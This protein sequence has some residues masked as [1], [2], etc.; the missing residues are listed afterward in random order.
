V[1]PALTLL[2]PIAHFATLARS[3]MVRAAAVDVVYVPLLVLMTIATVLVGVSAWRFR[4]QMS[5]SPCH[6]L[7]RGGLLLW[8]W[9]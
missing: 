5:W 2:N 8:I 4:G 3:M 6:A 1:D 7:A 9:G